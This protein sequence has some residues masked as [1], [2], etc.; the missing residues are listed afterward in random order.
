[1]N[2]FEFL[3]DPIPTTEYAALERLK[4]CMYNVVSTRVPSFLIES[5]SYLQVT[6]TAIKA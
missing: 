5:Y 1:M 2:E 3:P 4:Q 6:R